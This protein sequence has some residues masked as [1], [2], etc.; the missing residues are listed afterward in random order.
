MLDRAGA[1]LRGVAGDGTLTFAALATTGDGATTFVEA[2]RASAPAWSTELGGTAG[3]LAT[4]GDLVGVTL[5]GKGTL[6]LAKDSLALRGDPGGVVV[7]LDRATGAVRWRTA[8]DASEW[9]LIS[10]I[11][12]DGDDFVVGGSFAGSLRA[13]SHVVTSAGGSDG[14][15][16]RVS[17][18]GDIVWLERT[19]GPGTDA[20]QG[21][22]AHDGRVAIAGTFSAGADLQGHAF[23]PFD[24]RSP[25]GDA[26]VAMLDDKGAYQ[27]HATFGGRADD[28]VA[29]ITFDAS[30]RVAVAASARETLTFGSSQLVTQG[31]GDGIVVWYGESGDK[32]AA[33]ALGGF[34]FDGLRAI[35]SVGDTIVVGGFFSGQLNLGGRSSL[36]GGGDDAFI[37][38]LDGSGTVITSWLVSGAG[39]EEVTALAPIPGGFVAGIAHTAAA[40]ID[41]EP[42]PA[43]K[44][45]M[46]GSALIVRGL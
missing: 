27:W 11:A 43:P 18:K 40:S 4:A 29:G 13:G 16:A 30:G 31:A 42:L 35:T 9:S 3:P 38:A 32:G 33:V 41:D 28:T 17:A 34:D 22:A 21:V 10:S 24:D 5:S 2:H 1:S 39:R 19:G 12:A 46:A 45:P 23:P 6:R 15:V 44:D 8:L 14:F 36:A 37:A 20:I 25:F 7:A 26:F